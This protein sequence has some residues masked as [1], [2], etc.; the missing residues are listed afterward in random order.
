M[1]NVSLASLFELIQLAAVGLALFRLVSLHSIRKY[2]FFFAYLLFR[3]PA[4]LC[5]IVLSLTSSTY[6]YFWIWTTPMNWLLHILVV[7]ELYG[8]IL[9]RHRGIYTLGRW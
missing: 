6:F 7:R 8:L 2:Q 4:T 1:P 3:I 5:T 9:A